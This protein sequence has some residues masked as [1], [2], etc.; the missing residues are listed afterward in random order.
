MNNENG[1][2]FA[3]PEIPTLPA[4]AGNALWANYRAT[5]QVSLPH[6]AS[7]A[8]LHIRCLKDTPESSMSLRLQGDGYWALT[9]QEEIL[10]DGTLPAES[11]A[12]TMTLGAMGTLLFCA[13]DGQSLYQVK[14][15]G[16]PLMRS[17]CIGR[18]GEDCCFADLNAGPL[19]LLPACHRK[20]SFPMTEWTGEAGSKAV[21]RFYGSGVFL[22]GETEEAEIAVYLDGNLYS[23]SVTIQNSHAGET[24]FSLDSMRKG[25]HTLSMQLLNGTLKLT[26]AEVPD[27]GKVPPDPMTAD[28]KPIP[29]AAVIGA[30]AGAAV[31]LTVLG[32]RRKKK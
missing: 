29:K 6:T 31:L 14:L 25:W 19:V 32:K 3:L 24:C 9:Y 17:G 22:L 5:V 15:D 7:C 28:G 20:L 16:K 8:Q 4:L 13:V 12:H 27:E 10:A 26:G 30:A 23:G 1:L 21:F 2:P 18:T 11:K